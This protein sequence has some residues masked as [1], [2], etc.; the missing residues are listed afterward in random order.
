MATMTDVLCRNIHR[1][2]WVGIVA[3]RRLETATPGDVVLFESCPSCR[4]SVAVSAVETAIWFSKG[5][6][7]SQS[8]LSVHELEDGKVLRVW[9]FARANS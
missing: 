6:Q 1:L 2:L 9:Y 5:V 7:R 8:S 4:S 3:P